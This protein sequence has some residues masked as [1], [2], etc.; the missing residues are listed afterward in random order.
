MRRLEDWQDARHPM[1]DGL[2]GWTRCGMEDTGDGESMVE[3]GDDGGGWR[4][5]GAWM[6][7]CEGWRQEG[8]RLVAGA[9]CRII[10][11]IMSCHTIYHHTIQCIC[12]QKKQSVMEM[13]RK[14]FAG[15]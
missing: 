2:E 14:E 6:M 4:W 5:I 12:E 1:W 10:I 9:E 13:N 7:E 3:E 11:I 15:N 8:T